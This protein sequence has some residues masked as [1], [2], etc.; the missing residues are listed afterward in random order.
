FLKRLSGNPAATKPLSAYVDI[1]PQV[2]VSGLSTCSLVSFVPMEAVDD[3]ATGR[4]R[5][6]SR[7]L[8]EVKKGYTPFAEGDILWAKITPC[9]QNGKSCIARGLQNSIG[10]GSTEFHVFRV[11]DS[12]VSAKFV[13]EFLSQESLRRV[14]TFAFTG[15]AGHQRVPDTF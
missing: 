8:A 10:F 2:D 7:P 3:G 15:S 13:W 5:L 11:R 9:M 4:V 1:N 12:E 6:Q 14:A